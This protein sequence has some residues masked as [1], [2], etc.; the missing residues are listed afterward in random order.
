MTRVLMLNLIN[1]GGT[2]GLPASVW[3][4]LGLMG[5]THIQIDTNWH[6]KCIHKISAK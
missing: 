1:A 2:G 3:F 4:R 6:D 5:G